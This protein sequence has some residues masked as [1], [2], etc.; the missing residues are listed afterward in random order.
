MPVPGQHNKPAIVIRLQNSN[1]E[2]IVVK[3]NIKVINLFAFLYSVIS[4]RRGACLCLS[5]CLSV[6]ALAPK[7]LD[8]FQRHSGSDLPVSFLFHFLNSP[9]WR[10]SRHFEKNEAALTRL[11][12]WSIFFFIVQYMDM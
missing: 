1:L 3:K 2:L 10:H 12:F 8:G 11:Q 6:E 4:Y 9:G 7:R 5:V